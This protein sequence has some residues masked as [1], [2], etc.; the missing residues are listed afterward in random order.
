MALFY[1]NL[2]IL[3]TCVLNEFE[4]LFIKNNTDN[5]GIVSCEQFIETIEK[6]QQKNINLNA[7]EIKNMYEEFHII[8]SKIRINFNDLFDTIAH[9]YTM[10]WNQKSYYDFVKLMYGDVRSVLR[11][12][13]KIVMLVVMLRRERIANR[14]RC[15][16]GCC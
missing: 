11:N 9:E 12:K 2:H 14:P 7:S 1:D 4:E 3:N 10:F 15:K 16:C 13:R 5:D 6:M 8:L